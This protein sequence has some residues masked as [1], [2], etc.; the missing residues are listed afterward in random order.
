[1]RHRLDRP[2]NLWLR[3][4]AEPPLLRVLA[5]VDDTDALRIEME[6]V[7]QL[8]A[9]YPG[10]LLNVWPEPPS[11]S[12]ERPLWEHY[13]IAVAW[14]A[15]SPLP[16]HHRRA[17]SRGKTGKPRS[18]ETKAKISATVTGSTWSPAQYVARGLQPRSQ[19]AVEQ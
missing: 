2:V 17:I 16:E 19:S 6:T 13:C 11:G 1:M 5:I 10:R 9:L 15:G 8:R 18:A 7:R 3:G 12:P 4:L 14:S